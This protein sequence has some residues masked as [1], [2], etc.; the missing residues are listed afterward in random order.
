MTQGKTPELPIGANPTFERRF[1]QDAE[2]YPTPGYCL[3]RAW[4]RYREGP[5]LSLSWMFQRMLLKRMGDSKPLQVLDPFCGRGSL[6]IELRRL[7][8]GFSLT[9][10][11]DL[12]GVEV[13][14]WHGSHA[15][16][17]DENGFHI[18]VGDFFRPPAQDWLREHGPFDAVVMN[19]PFSLSDQF[20]EWWAEQERRPL[21]AMYQRLGWF[22]GVNRARLLRRLDIN[23]SILVLP[24]RVRHRPGKGTDNSNTAWFVFGPGH[25]EGYAHGFVEMLE[26]TPKE[27]RER[28]HERLFG[29]P[30]GLYSDAVEG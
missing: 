13:Q 7:T 26:T 16:M 23:P 22:G 4:S 9:G 27:E 20:L 3:R 14:P 1:G 18:F 28:D 30:D 24:E 10:D 15:A 5:S 6:L 19:P 29:I 11:V 17:A 8:A 2:D 12:Y 21:V 25:D